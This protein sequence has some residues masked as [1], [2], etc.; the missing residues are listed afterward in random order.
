MRL[1]AI[2]KMALAHLLTDGARSVNSNIG[3]YGQV[4][5]DHSLVIKFMR[6]RHGVKVQFK[7]KTRA[8]KRSHLTIAQ[9][10]IGA[11]NNVPCQKVVHVLV[12]IIKIWQHGCSLMGGASGD[13]SFVKP[14]DAYINACRL[15][16]AR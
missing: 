10:N 4:I 12:A 16:N 15:R 6:A 14:M 2:N 9:T 7:P 11:F 8:S 1:F 5:S 13:S 3:E